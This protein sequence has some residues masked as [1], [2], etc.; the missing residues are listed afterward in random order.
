LSAV[1][2]SPPAAIGAAKFARK[3]F[4]VLPSFT[5]AAIY[6]AAARSGREAP[7]VGDELSGVAI[8]TA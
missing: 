4:G 3:S 7:V 5:N 6:A 2:E 1:E 8:L